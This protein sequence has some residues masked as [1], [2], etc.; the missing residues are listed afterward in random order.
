[1]ASSAI[2]RSLS[3]QSTNRGRLMEAQDIAAEIFRGKRSA[4]WVRRNLPNKITLGHST[5]M[6]YEADVWDYIHS[7][8]NVGPHYQPKGDLE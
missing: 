2:H 7:C 6:W 4:E 3:S 8:R 1:L 5:V